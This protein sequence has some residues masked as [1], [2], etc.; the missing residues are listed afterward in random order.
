MQMAFATK[1]KK[2]NYLLK[3]HSIQES[4]LGQS[5]KTPNISHFT[6]IRRDRTD[7]QGLMTYIKCNIS[8]SQLKHQTSQ[9]LKPWWKANN[10]SRLKLIFYCDLVG[11]SY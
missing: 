1:H 4:K 5:H 6:F 2:Y 10:N 8:F 11:F 7:K 3:I 9:L